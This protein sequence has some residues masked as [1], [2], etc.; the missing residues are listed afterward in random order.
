MAAG[1]R[2]FLLAVVHC[3]DLNDGA[4]GLHLLL[5]LDDLAAVFVVHMQTDSLDVLIFHAGEH[6]EACHGVVR[7]KFRRRIRT[8]RVL[9]SRTLSAKQSA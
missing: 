3:C 9:A 7:F 4:V 8:R 1:V 2:E 6:G 5:S